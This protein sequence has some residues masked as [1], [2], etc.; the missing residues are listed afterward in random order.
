M[1]LLLASLAEPVVETLTTDRSHYVEGAITAPRPL[2]EAATALSNAVIPVVALSALLL[3]LLWSKV[4]GTALV[5]CALPS[6]TMAANEFVHG[7]TVGPSLFLPALAGGLL[8]TLR[9][10]LSDLVVLGHAGGLVA[11][12][13]L[14]GFAFEPSMV[15]MSAGL[16]HADKSLTGAPL[17]AGIFSHSNTL[18]LFLV[19]SLPFVFLERRF[20][21]RWPIVVVIA[22]ALVLSSARTALFGAGVV[23][24]AV[25]LGWLLPR[26]AFRV[27]AVA[28][29]LVL[30]ALVVHTPFSEHDPA[31]YTFR[32]EIW[33][34]NIAQLS[35]HMLFGR[36]AWYYSDNYGVLKEALSSAASHAH[37]GLLTTLMVGGL[38]TLGAVLVVIF[39]AWRGADR[40]PAR[41][42][43]IVGVASLTGLLAVSI[44]ETTLRFAGW[45]PLSASLLVPLF[46]YVAAAV[47]PPTP[48]PA[49]RLI[50]GAVVP[51]TRRSARASAAPTR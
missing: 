35:G 31:A 15:L 27:V 49:E 5:I 1:L 17:L 42:E 21:I 34:F 32:G 16:A 11:S 45:G 13:S 43:M 8:V 6:L 47:T 51:L 22:V 20:W 3:V 36:G 44:T 25:A 28:G 14:W 7:R 23:L 39:F 48:L 38:V 30:S 9:V 33:I 50:D 46:V 29:L 37:N 10:K 18:G 4:N 12:L 24:V 2:V 19:V 26:I 40:A 41:R